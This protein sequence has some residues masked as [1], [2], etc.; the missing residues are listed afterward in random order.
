MRGIISK[1]NK[2][3]KNFWHK[4]NINVSQKKIYFSSQKKVYKNMNHIKISIIE[5]PSQLPNKSIEMID[6]CF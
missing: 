1:N 3:I 5:P 4:K 2:Y 6:I